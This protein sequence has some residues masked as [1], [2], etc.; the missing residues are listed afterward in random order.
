MLSALNAS[1]N[2]PPAILRRHRWGAFADAALMSTKGLV[3]VGGPDGQAVPIR[4]FC[5]TEFVRL[6]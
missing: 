6:G 5:R 3:G 2:V 4:A 1:T